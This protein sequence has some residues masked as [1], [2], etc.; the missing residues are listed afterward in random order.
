MNFSIP[1]LTLDE[2]RGLIWI[3]VNQPAT[4]LRM[5]PGAP[6]PKVRQ[7]LLERGF[8]HFDPNRKRYDPITYC[9]TPAGEA[10]LKGR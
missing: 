7:A 3:K 2:R 10:V 9:L 1:L 4:I 6:S 5:T 8:I